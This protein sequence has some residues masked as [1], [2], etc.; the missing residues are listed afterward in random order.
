MFTL[1]MPIARKHNRQR[2]RRAGWLTVGV[3]AP[4]V[5]CMLWDF[6]EGGCRLTAPHVAAL[7]ELFTLTVSANSDVQHHCRVIW[8]RGA[9]V[10]VQFIDA[11][12]A[13]RL[14]ETLPNDGTSGLY[15]NNDRDSFSAAKRKPEPKAQAAHAKSAR[16]RR[17]FNIQLY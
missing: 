2:M 7:P 8:R 13:K 10:G 5:R 1:T 9:Y 4:P 12:E 15:L 17:R 16:K 6:S 11:A 14:S 3:G